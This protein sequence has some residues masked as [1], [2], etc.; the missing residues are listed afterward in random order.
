MCTPVC[1]L[2]TVPNIP[3]LLYIALPCISVISGF[4]IGIS[5]WYPGINIVI[6]ISIIALALALNIHNCSANFARKEQANKLNL[7]NTATSGFVSSV[8]TPIAHR[9]FLITVLQI[10]YDVFPLQISL[11]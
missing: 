6:S 4:N 10:C 11:Y 5:I 7:M 9:F 1:Q 2:W 3:L 8:L